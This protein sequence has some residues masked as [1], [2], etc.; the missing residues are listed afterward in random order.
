MLVSNKTREWSQLECT[1]G[2]VDVTNLITGTNSRKNS[3]NC[4][5]I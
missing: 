1:A 4:D 2:T 5:L 3:V